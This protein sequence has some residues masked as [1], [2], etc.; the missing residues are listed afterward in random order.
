METWSARAMATLDASPPSTGSKK[1]TGVSALVI[2]L[3]E[4]DDPSQRIARGAP[5]T[6]T[7]RP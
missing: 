4:G 2:G 7:V 1:C 5:S 6:T 3:V